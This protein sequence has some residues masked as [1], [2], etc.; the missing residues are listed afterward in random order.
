MKYESHIGHI[1]SQ[2][3]DLHNGSLVIT[4]VEGKMVAQLLDG[5]SKQVRAFDISFSNVAIGSGH[6]NSPNMGE[7][8]EE[9]G[10]IQQRFPRRHT[11]VSQ[12]LRQRT[13][14]ADK[15]PKTQ[16]TN[17]RPWTDKGKRR[18]YKRKSKF[19]PAEMVK[20]EKDGIELLNETLGE[21]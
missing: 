9:T 4:C 20:I 6:V 3:S 21:W 14:L 7:L 11:F 5:N 16:R 8:D 10:V 1:L 13:H 2:L 19:T 15:K 12:K 17:P 18:K